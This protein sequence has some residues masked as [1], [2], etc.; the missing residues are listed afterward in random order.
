M[1]VLNSLAEINISRILRLIWIEK[2]ISRVDI[3]SRLGMDK[4]TVTKI[5]SE[6][7]GQ[8]IIREAESGESGPQGGRKPVFLE[9]N[10]D[11]A[12]VGGIEINPQKF[13]CSLLNL[14]GE[15]VFEYSQNIDCDEYKKLGLT[16]FFEKAYNIIKKNADSKNATLLGIGV[17]LPA[18]IDVSQGM[19]IQSIPMMIYEPV[20][21]IKKVQEITNLP[22]FFDNDA[23]CCCYTEKMIWRNLSSE[24][25]MMYVLVQHRP[26]QPVKDSP[27]NISV[28]FGFVLNGKIYH[29]ANSTAGEFRSMLWKPSSQSQFATDTQGVSKLSDKAV[30]GIFKELA[31]NVAFLVN[32]LNL[33][34]VYV[35]GIEK[36]YAE[37]LVKYIREDIEYLWPYEWNKTSDKAADKTSMVTSAIISDRVVSV[38]A[39]ILVLDNLFGVPELGDGNTVSTQ[40]YNNM[41]SYQWLVSKTEH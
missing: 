37:E 32:T 9:L 36:A 3:A 1:R 12:F 5:V 11:L 31:Q 41:S 34:V 27:E 35:G 30:T 22:V 21:F 40:F 38:G 24:K 16:G 10:G 15:T 28:G 8:G 29:G 18:L 2:K 7:C 6:L 20:D 14:N 19:I 4:S 33:D 13:L 26:Q 23:R 39:G 25:N 17:G